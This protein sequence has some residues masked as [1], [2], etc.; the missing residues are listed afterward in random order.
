MRTVIAITAVGEP[1]MIL[2]DILKARAEYVIS[3]K[4]LRRGLYRDTR[5]CG[6]WVRLK[7]SLVTISAEEA[8]E[9]VIHEIGALYLFPG[10]IDEFLVR[11]CKVPM[12]SS[13]KRCPNAG[14]GEY[15]V[16]P[17][18]EFFKHV[19]ACSARIKK[20]YEKRIAVIDGDHDDCCTSCC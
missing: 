1:G 12:E 5:Q 6:V 4:W 18:S 8:E 13:T 17:P 7:N 2:F 3:E 16:A 9:A 19:I 14:C 20:K 10:T 11:F 15:F